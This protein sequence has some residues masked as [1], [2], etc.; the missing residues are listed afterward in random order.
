MGVRAK[1]KSGEVYLA[2]RKD[3]RTK[4]VPKNQLSRSVFNTLHS[5][6]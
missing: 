2:D 1:E 5:Q 6:Q 4:L 3:F